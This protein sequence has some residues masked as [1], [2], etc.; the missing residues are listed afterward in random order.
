M[1]WEYELGGSMEEPSGVIEIFYIL[2][3]F[4]QM[5]L[6]QLDHMQKFSENGIMI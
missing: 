5:V 4:E 1:K 3:S 6:R 2:I